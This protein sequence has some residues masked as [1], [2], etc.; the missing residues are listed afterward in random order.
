MHHVRYLFGFNLATGEDRKSKRNSEDSKRTRRNKRRGEGSRI[1]ESLI[2]P[3]SFALVAQ[4]SSS[5]SKYTL[6]A[7]KYFLTNTRVRTLSRS[8]LGWKNDPCDIFSDDASSLRKSNALVRRIETKQKVFKVPCPLSFPFC[9]L[10]I[11]FVL[12]LFRCW[13]CPLGA[14]SNVMG[15]RTNGLRHCVRIYWTRP[16]TKVCHCKL[17]FVH[18]SP[19]SPRKSP[20]NYRSSALRLRISCPVKIEFSTSFAV[21]CWYLGK[22]KFYFVESILFR[23]NY[24]VKLNTTIVAIPW[25]FYFSLLRVYYAYFSSFEYHIIA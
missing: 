1:L 6:S 5:A 4:T 9:F 18:A 24:N 8:N 22:L 20:T 16:W 7:C 17:W 23:W 11:L 13:H 14:R 15:S 21:N 19:L 2:H 12:F 25:T 3:A 10:W